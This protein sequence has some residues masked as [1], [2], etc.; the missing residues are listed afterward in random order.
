MLILDNLCKR[1]GSKPVLQRLCLTLHPGEIYGLLGPNGAGKTTTINIICGLLKADAGVVLIGGQPASHSTK[2]WVGV[3]PQ[4]NLLYSG[5]TCQHNLF[6]LGRLYGLSR[7]ECRQRIEVCLEAVDL[8]AQRH[9]RVECLS[10][11]MQR[12]LSLAAALLHRPK[13]IILDE[14]T[15]GLDIEARHEVWQLI[16]QLRTMGVTILLTSHL[17]DEVE[18]LCQRVGILKQGQIV[19][20][21][22]L[23]E[24]QA[25]IPAYE[26]I[27]VETDT[28]ELAITRAQQLGYPHRYYS[29]DLAFWV[30]DKLDLKELIARFDGVPL[31]SVARQ[32]VRLE[33]IYLE[34]TRPV[35]ANDLF[36]PEFTPSPDGA[37]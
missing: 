9:T 10:G 22:T 24:L 31:D 30:P 1:Y 4:N 17:F 35:K 18:R 3:V 21:G 16:R 20:E 23:K 8:S 14:P 27:T 15:T 11:G 26:I 34:V 6:F 29:G 28:P 36:S 32:P 7:H 19:A 37:R 13:L 2:H 12:R 33:H 25:R 5:L